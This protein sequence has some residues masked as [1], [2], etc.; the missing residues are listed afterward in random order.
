MGLGSA[1]G[2]NTERS[3][4]SKCVAGF[5]C[6]NNFLMCIW[7]IIFHL[8]VDTTVINKTPIHL[9][10]LKHWRNADYIWEIMYVINPQLS[11]ALLSCRGPFSP[12]PPI[13]NTPDIWKKLELQIKLPLSFTVV[14]DD[15]ISLIVISQRLCP[16]PIA[17]F[18][19]CKC[20]SAATLLLERVCEP[21]STM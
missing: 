20:G 11:K 3:F 6:I 9:Q 21:Y 17:F 12:C 18:L 10:A 5:V 19:H 2:K 16:T 7:N 15:L 13:I 4:A 1:D 14:W 8:Y